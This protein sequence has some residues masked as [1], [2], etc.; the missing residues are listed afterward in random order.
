MMQKEHAPLIL[1]SIL[2][3]PKYYKMQKKVFEVFASQQK[4]SSLKVLE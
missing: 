4:A 1:S 3:L 2:P